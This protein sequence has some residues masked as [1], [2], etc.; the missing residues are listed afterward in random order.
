M[1]LDITSKQLHFR[2]YVEV[3]GQILLMP[4]FLSLRVIYDYNNND[5]DYSDNDNDDDITLSDE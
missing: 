2:F 4:I 5:D 1:Q 3:I